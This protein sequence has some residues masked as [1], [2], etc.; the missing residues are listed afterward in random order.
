MPLRKVKKQSSALQRIDSFFIPY[1]CHYN[2][3][4][5]LTKNG[6]LCQTL[7]ITGF[8]FELIANEN[9]DLR[10]VIRNTIS[11]HIPDENFAI[12][13]HTIRRKK[14]LGFEFESDNIFCNFL[15]KEWNDL[16]DWHHKYVNELYI[17][18][19]T[20][21]NDYSLAKLKNLIFSLSFVTLQYAE[22][23]FLEKSYNKLSEVV[24]NIAQDLN[25]FG[26][27][28]LSLIKGSD[29]KKDAKGVN[30]E[31][32]N[33]YSENLRFFNKIT[34]LEDKNFIIKEQDLAAQLSYSDI[35]FG[36][37]M[38]QIK[39][40]KKTHYATIFSIK[41]Y[42]EL[43]LKSLDKFLNL[44]FEFLITQTLDF[45]NSDTALQN[46]QKQQDI[47]DVSNDK[48]FARDSGLTDILDIANEDKKT[49]YG[50]QQLTIMLFADSKKDLERDIIDAGTALLE[51]GLVIIREDMFMEH[52]YFSQ[53]PTNFSYL[54]RKH[55]INTNQFAGFASLLNYPAGRKKHNKWGDAVTVFYTENKTPYFF[56]F[57]YKDNGHTLLVGPE[58]SGKTV[59]LNFLIAQAQKFKNKLY[60]L[61]FFNSSKIFVK[62]L[63]GK[64]Y[65]FSLQGSFFNIA[66]FVDN[67]E[68]FIKLIA[69]LIFDK[70]DV[71]EDT[72][73]ISSKKQGFL[74]EIYTKIRTKKI[75]G[76]DD[77]KEFF[78]GSPYEKN[79][80]KWIQGGKYQSIFDSKTD[81]WDSGDIVGFDF[82]DLQKKP[83]LFIPIVFY[84]LHQIEKNL[85][86]S[87]TII[88]IDE[89]F[90][91]LD[92]PF[93]T[94][95][96]TGFLQRVAKKNAVVIMAQE[97]IKDIEKSNITDLLMSEIST[98]FYF[99]NEKVGNSYKNIFQLSTI[100][101]EFLDLIKRDQR[102]FLLKH[103]SDSL[104]AE[105]DLEQLT[106]IL[107]ILSSDDQTIEAMEVIIDDIGE[108]PDKWFPHLQKV[109]NDA[110]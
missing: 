78:V 25:N 63:K 31:D 58:G 38:L 52:C 53:M 10:E 72:Y 107:L 77:I 35:F 99:A 60:Y 56:N 20:K 4:T 43:S 29:I 32:E 102:K 8:D 81:I 21:E 70:D 22:K 110:R 75:T 47:L 88:V 62:A 33:Y 42:S 80:S 57:H 82:T 36:K 84:S 17:T 46:Y 97:S 74:E 66:N 91:L 83:A 92:N 54:S 34:N 45:V 108:D 40:D 5:I 105:L 55:Y 24:D 100:E 13:L 96:I 37:N 26:V 68:R 3:D 19:V 93:I 50:E 109:L 85:D 90:K 69:L 2:F 106:E 65:D 41:E 86:G 76:I 61:D 11:D 44:P 48:Y 18:I 89:A 28:K 103:G 64:Y 14:D 104:V 59:L 23:N 16:H 6:N 1:A 15:N 7:K 9:K 71:S 95:E 30:L 94:P 51:Y 73:K 12:Y 98:S 27:K 87:K 39:N 49:N 67:K 101:R 79:F